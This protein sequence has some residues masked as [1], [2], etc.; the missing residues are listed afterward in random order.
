VKLV[1]RSLPLP[2]SPLHL[3]GTTHPRQRCD[4]HFDEKTDTR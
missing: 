2:R 1:A 3:H 4:H